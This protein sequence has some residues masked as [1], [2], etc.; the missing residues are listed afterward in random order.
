MSARINTHRLH[1]SLAIVFGAVLLMWLIS[2]IAI[3]LPP[4]G[5]KAL[6]PAAQSAIDYSALR[7]SPADVVTQAQETLGVKADVQDMALTQIGGRVY[8]EIR[9]TGSESTLI[10]AR[11]GELF[12]ITAEVA[13]EIAEIQVQDLPVVMVSRVDRHSL[14]YPWGQLP[15]YRVSFGD[16]RGTQA[17]VSIRNGAVRYV[18]RTTLLRT[19]LASLHDLS[20]LSLAFGIEKVKKEL[21][22]LLSL[23]SIA[24]VASG[25]Y[26]AIAVGRTNKLRISSGTSGTE[27]R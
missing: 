12:N 23:G 1:K 18:D 2:G 19:A 26:L 16:A 11:S 17:Y 15:V 4:P 10:D 6:Q 25:Y 24:V 21:L 27:P 13:S 5:I 14:A 8:Y 20:L 9:F 3:L 7:I 22:L